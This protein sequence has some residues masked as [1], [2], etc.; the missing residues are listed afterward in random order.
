MDMADKTIR[1]IAGALIAGAL[2]G[3]YAFVLVEAIQYARGKGESPTEGAFWILHTIGGLVSALVAAQLAVTPRP[4]DTGRVRLF[5]LGG[6]P[7]DTMATIIA[8]LY[9][10]VWLALGFAAVIVGLVDYK[11]EVVRLADFAK[12]WIGLA[13]AAAYAYFGIRAPGA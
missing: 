6:M 12:A 3:L 9:L 10:A 8:V 13:L 7:A 4:G 5:V 11:H 1:L 2:L